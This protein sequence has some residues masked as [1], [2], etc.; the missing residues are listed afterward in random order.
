MQEGRLFVLRARVHARGK[1]L[2]SVALPSALVAPVAK[3]LLDEFSRVI[4]REHDPP[5]STRLAV[6]G[7]ASPA[8]GHR[9]NNRHQFQ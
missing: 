1:A 5:A 8:E 7:H 6:E 9:G 3:N 2:P 4:R